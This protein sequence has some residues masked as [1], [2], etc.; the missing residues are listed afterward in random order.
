MNDNTFSQ[1][2]KND[3]IQQIQVQISSKGWAVLPWSLCDRTLKKLKQD[4]DSL[5]N[6]VNTEVNY[7]GSECRIWKAHEKS[8]LIDEFRLFSDSTVSDIEGA[9]CRSFDILA[10]RNK[11]IDSSDDALTKGRWHLDSFSRQLKIF[12][13]LTDVTTSSGAFE[14][15]PGS[16]ATSF[17]MMKL[18]AGQLITPKDIINGTRSYSK[19]KEEVIQKVLSTGYE[20][21][22]FDVPRG[23]MAIV[24]TSCIHRA[25][26]C[27]DGIRYALTSYY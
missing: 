25:K 2:L 24:D 10:I 27:T 3:Q 15:I 26:P 9:E 8:S 5:S 6:E 19:L 11:S 4:I 22:T 23:T 18:L 14:M 7:G 16:H 1:K 17:K 12:V 13:F 21:K 20:V